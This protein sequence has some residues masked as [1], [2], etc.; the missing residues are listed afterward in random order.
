[1]NKKL[2]FAVILFLWAA[3]AAVATHLSKPNIII[4]LA[5]DMGYGDCGVY[6]SE[7]KIKTPHIDQLAEEGLLFTDAHA[8]ASTCT[9]SRYGLLTGTN[10]VRTG[11]LNTLL[12]RGDPIIGEGEKTIAAML[13]DQG[14]VARMIGKWHLGFEADKSGKRPALDFSKSLM[15]GPLDHG[16]DSFYGINSSLSSSPMCFTRDRSVVALPTEKGTIKKYNADGTMSDVKV[17]K[18][19]GCRP[20]DASPLFCLEALKIIREQAASSDAKPLFLYYASPAP[21]QPWVPSAAFRGKS[22]LGDYADYVMQL[23]D[24]VG[25]INKA[26]KQTGLD[27]NTLLIFTTDNG[28]GPKAVKVMAR[29]GHA[30]SATLR[31][32]KADSWEGGH[33]IPFIAK[34]PGRI[35]RNQTTTAVINFTDI[36]AT[37]AEL[38]QVDPEKSYPGSAADSHSFLPVL[39][40]SSLN[41]KRPGMMFGRGFVRD[42]DWKLVSKS[43][44]RRM[45]VVKQSQFELFQLSEDLSEMHDLSK[46]NPERAQRLFQA[47]SK[48]AESRELK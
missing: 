31:G 19:P 6:N 34:W 45:D 20:E 8:A 32:A 15:G 22:G 46:S 44:V 41:Y 42:G 1:M 25:Q 23:D 4:I 11:V 28:T 10:P 26:L 29:R 33:R 5:D 43:R 40:S 24:V 7:S 38:L 36:F 39:W 30:S 3:T 14:Y 9:P 17:M 2:S 35:V 16:F 18:S 12:E 27:K 47:F 21:H 13:K 48:Y 37:F